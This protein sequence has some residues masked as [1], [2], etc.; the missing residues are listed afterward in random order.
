MPPSTPASLPA[1]PRA[2]DQSPALLGQLPNGEMGTL[3]NDSAAMA[4]EY[5]LLAIR[6]TA[7]RDLYNCARSQLNEHKTMESCL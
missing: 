4:R 2:I 3:A 6:F 5:G 7:L 1:I